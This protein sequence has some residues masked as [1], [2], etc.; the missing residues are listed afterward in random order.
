MLPIDQRRLDR[1][2]RK[3]RNR[4]ATTGMPD[5]ELP[6]AAE[7][8]AAAEQADCAGDPFAL[9]GIGRVDPFASAVKA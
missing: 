3:V 7:A 2:A 1:A 8:L 6:T 5:A 9:G 4:A